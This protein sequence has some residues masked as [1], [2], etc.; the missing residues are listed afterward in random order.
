M[1]NST[2]ADL[3]MANDEAEMKTPIASDKQILEMDEVLP[4]IGEFGKFQILLEIALCIMIM[5]GSML[6]L[7]PYF[8]QHNPPWKCVKNS[9]I[10]S[11]QGEVSSSSKAE[12][13]EARCRMPRSDWEFTKPKDYS[14]ITQVRKWALQERQ[15]LTPSP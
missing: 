4:L 11:F 9:T 12:V 1:L 8:A 13:Y 6:V 14:V 5:P 7:I 2:V 3:E 10:C 15:R